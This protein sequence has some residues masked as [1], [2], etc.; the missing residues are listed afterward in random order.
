MTTAERLR[1]ISAK[2]D[3]DKYWS[4]EAYVRNIEHHMERSAQM[5]LEHLYWIPSVDCGTGNPVPDKRRM[6]RIIQRLRDKG[7]RAKIARNEGVLD[8]SW[9]EQ[10][11]CIVM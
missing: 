8:I 9:G 7:I 3:D 11:W 1:A 2:A 6:E 5:K 10:S 4:I